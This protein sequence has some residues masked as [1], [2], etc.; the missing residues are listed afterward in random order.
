[1]IK[2]AL[3]AHAIF[4]LLSLVLGF[5]FQIVVVKALSPENYVIYA[6]LLA[7]LTVG[8]RLL[9]L[10]IGRTIL[11]FV[12]GF[13]LRHDTSGVRFLVTRLGLLRIASLILFIAALTASSGLHL[14]FTPANLT[15]STIA[16]FGVWFVAFTL[17]T[18]ANVIA[19]SLIAHRSAALV[20]ATEAF[21]RTATVLLLYVVARSIDVET[22]IIVSAVTSLAACGVLTCCIALAA[23][24]RRHSV[25]LDGASKI[26][27]AGATQGQ[28]SL[29]AAAAYASTLSYL[30]SSPGVIRLVA[31]TGLDVIALAAYSFV[32]GLTMAL[33]RALPGM[34]ILPS[35][36]PVAAQ[37][38]ESGRAHKMLPVLSLLFKIELTCVLAIIIAAQS[39]GAEII[40]ALS[41]PAY[42]P[43]YYVLPMLLVAL[44]LN[45]VYRMLEILGSI[46]LKYKIFL[47]MWPLSVLAVATLYLT[48]GTWGLISVL[49]VPVVE[50][51][52]RVGILL[53]AFRKNGVWG[54][55]DPGRSLRLVVSAVVVLIGSSYALGQHDAGFH[56][57]DFMVAGGGLIVFLLAIFLVRPLSA[58]ECEALATSLPRSWS[59]PR[60]IARVLTSA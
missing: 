49:A 43:Y 56:S 53:F 6:V 24:R 4:R 27:P 20:A 46:S 44:L 10:G 54:A 9:S 47:S 23:S 19:Q 12:P 41:R 48:V 13:V 11:R 31:T 1:M 33:Q 52:V 51:V 32:Q 40:A 50:M 21:L 30:I 26:V 58:L 38:A 5:G 16:A 7:T 15:T 36:E 34:L 2:R 29:F 60:Y 35:L 3:Q 17:L 28:V 37:M 55:L 59:F 22:V 42:A 14:G 57:A 25:P 18:D 8:E 45:T 39:A